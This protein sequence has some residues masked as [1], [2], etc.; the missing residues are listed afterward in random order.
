MEKII[1]YPELIGYIYD[2]YQR[3]QTA[4]ESDATRAFIYGYVKEPLR[5]EIIKRG[6]FSD[7]EHTKGIITTG[8]ESFKRNVAERIFNE[9]YDELDLNLCPQC[10]K[11]ARTPQAKQCRFCL[12][13]WH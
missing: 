5:S 4:E 7:T 6:W 10:G 8:F 11:I 9:H 12:H 2:Y 1:L 3:F 13:D